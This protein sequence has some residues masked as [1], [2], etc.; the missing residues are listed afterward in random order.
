V[1]TQHF[2]VADD[3]HHTL[4]VRVR[5]T[6]SPS[7][8]MVVHTPR[9]VVDCTVDTIRT[10]VGCTV[11][12][13]DCRANIVLERLEKNTADLLDADLIDQNLEMSGERYRWTC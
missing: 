3:V 8:Q 2:E 5:W 10:V 12:L 11:A 1:D 9:R 6:D 13:E 7:E 4:L